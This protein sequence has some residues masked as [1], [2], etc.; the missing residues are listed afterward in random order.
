M[1]EKVIEIAMLLWLNRCLA[2]F[3]NV[4]PTTGLDEKQN[5]RSAFDWL[6]PSWTP[7]EDV[8]LAITR[9]KQIVPHPIYGWAPPRPSDAARIFGSTP[10]T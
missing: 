5:G 4:Y 1:T 9:P 2:A 7:L 3:S 6:R 8:L 10:S